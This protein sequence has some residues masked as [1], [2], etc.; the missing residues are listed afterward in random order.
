MCFTIV[1]FPDPD[2]ADTMMHFPPLATMLVDIEQLFFDFFQ[3]V[4]HLYHQAL[5]TYVVGF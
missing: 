4:F 3:L 1:V 5:Y 2:G